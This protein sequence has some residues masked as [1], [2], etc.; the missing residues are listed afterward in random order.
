MFINSLETMTIIL[1][2]H[3]GRVNK[4]ISNKRLKSTYDLLHTI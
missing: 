4:Y 3:D 1:N 2:T